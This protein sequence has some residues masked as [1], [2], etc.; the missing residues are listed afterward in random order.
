M[1]QDQELLLAEDKY[2]DLILD[3]VDKEGIIGGKR[4]LLMTA[5][6]VIVYD[7][8]KGKKSK[9]DIERINNIIAEIKKRQEKLLL[10]DP[11]IRD[12]IKKVVYPKLQLD[13]R[14]KP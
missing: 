1:E 5:L 14:K 12:Y 3:V 8:L 11:W 7:K 10:A 13:W 6:C 2:V 4:D 9:K